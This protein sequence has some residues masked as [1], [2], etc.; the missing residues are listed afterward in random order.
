MEREPDEAFRK[1]SAVSEF[2]LDIHL[3]P[4]LQV[5]IVVK[6]EM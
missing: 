1:L 6:T 4:L 2:A 5:L 3:A